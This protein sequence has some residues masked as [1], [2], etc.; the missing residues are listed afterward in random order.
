LHCIQTRPMSLGVIR[1]NRTCVCP[2]MIH[3][4][5][6]FYCKYSADLLV[7]CLTHNLMHILLWQLTL[8]EFSVE[9][10][11]GSEAALIRQIVPLHGHW[12]C[13]SHRT[14]VICGHDEN[15]GSIEIA[16]VRSGACGDFPWAPGPLKDSVWGWAAHTSP[17][18][19]PRL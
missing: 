7:N 16:A 19:G 5:I 2:W 13:K 18:G 15:R 8:L 10:H 1:S 12:Q 3:V 14:Y 11:K 17:R 9:R 6:L 4:S